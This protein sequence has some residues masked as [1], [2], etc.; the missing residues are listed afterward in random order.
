MDELEMELLYL[1][2]MMIYLLFHDIT[3]HCDE[4]IYI[5]IEQIYIGMV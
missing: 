2:Q 5:Q 4:K 1:Q 3:L